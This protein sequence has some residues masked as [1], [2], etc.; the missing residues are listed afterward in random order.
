[1]VA[2]VGPNGAGKTTLL[3]AVSGL[4]PTVSTAIELGGY[5]ID[6]HHPAAIAARGAGRSFQNPALLDDAPALENLVAGSHRHLGYTMLDQV[7]RPSRVRRNEA[8][9]S[10]RARSVL[11]YASMSSIADAPA[12]GL[13]YGS[14]KLL[15]ILRTLMGRPRL[16]LLDEP[17]SG[18]DAR[19]RE[20]VK[21]LIHDL[22]TSTNLGMLVVEH[23]MDIVRAVA[24]RVVGLQAGRVVAVGTPS[25]VLDSEAFRTTVVGG[26]RSEAAQDDHGE[27]DPGDDDE[28]VGTWRS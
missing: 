19:E 8:E 26:S 27:A 11:E 15:D 23:H 21:A 7:I 24:D 13:S 6:G 18:L 2:L 14:R 22:R 12:G 20:V 1:V 10:A 3:N 9:M 4:A 28:G 16:L 5:R 17:T 25:E